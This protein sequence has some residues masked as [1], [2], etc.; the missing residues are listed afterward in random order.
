MYI[1]IP[2]ALLEIIYTCFYALIWY[3]CFKCNSYL[4]PQVFLPQGQRWWWCLPRPGSL[5]PVCAR[6]LW[7]SILPRVRTGIHLHQ[8][9]Q[10]QMCRPQWAL[11]P[12]Q[13]LCLQGLFGEDNLPVDLWCSSPARR[14]SA[15]KWSAQGISRIF[16]PVRQH[17]WCSLACRLSSMLYL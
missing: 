11:K 2:A 4:P 14:S 1:W 6:D 10:Q 15:Q 8:G 17:P 3:M 16:P 7:W 9:T 5:C 12:F 13:L